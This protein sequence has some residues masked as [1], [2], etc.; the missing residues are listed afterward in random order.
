[1]EAMKDYVAHLDNKKRI[2][3]RGAAYQYYNV[4]EYGNGC[5]ILEPRELAVPESISARTLADMN[6]AVSNF[7]RGDVFPAIDLSDLQNQTEYGTKYEQ[8][9]YKKQVSCFFHAKKEVLK[10]IKKILC[11][12]NNS[13]VSLLEFNFPESQEWIEKLFKNGQV[14]TQYV[15][16]NG[17]P[18]MDDRFN[19]NGSYYAI[20]GITSPDGR[21]LGKMAHSER[22]GDNIAKNIYAKQDQKIFESGV[23]YFK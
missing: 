20:E 4:K 3:L 5:I 16:L 18:T 14:A 9:V 21:V 2:T 15:N 22:I 23:E 13:N 12:Y 8:L 17:E 19:P 10:K 6:R 1:M 11:I 7:K